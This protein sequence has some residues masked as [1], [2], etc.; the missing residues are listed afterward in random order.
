MN[1]KTLRRSVSL[2]RGTCLREPGIG[3]CSHAS[4]KR[5]PA[6]RRAQSRARAGVPVNERDAQLQGAVSGRMPVRLLPKAGPRLS[7][8]ASLPP[9][10]RDGIFPD[11]KGNSDC[12]RGC[13]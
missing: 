5:E 13:L 12:G 7:R 9:T 8:G 3:I 6:E 10:D 1:K 4:Y 2:K 11:G